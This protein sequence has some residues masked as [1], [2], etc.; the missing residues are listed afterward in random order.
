MCP[1]PPDGVRGADAPGAPPSPA[2]R[3]RGQGPGPLRPTGASGRRVPW[4]PRPIAA[5]GPPQ[6]GP[7]GGA[8][9]ASP[10]GP[11]ARP[12]APAVP[13]RSPH[14]GE[15]P[16]SPDP[17]RGPRSSGGSG[18]T[19]A[20]EIPRDKET[21]RQAPLPRSRGGKPHPGSPARDTEGRWSRGEPSEGPQDTL[22]SDQWAR[23]SQAAFP[24]REMPTGRPL[25]SERR[26]TGPRAPAPFRPPRGRL[27]AL[28]PAPRTPG[29]AC[30]HLHP[31]RGR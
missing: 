24:S 11:G 7:G 20:A 26:A 30:R 6:W 3:A 13:Y 8:D 18:N 2:Q 9:R 21:R 12:A 29:F 22:F 25:A 17:G 19:R 14:L 28:G 15:S 5:S 27:A 1:A 10:G 23:D 4:W 31:A 16:V